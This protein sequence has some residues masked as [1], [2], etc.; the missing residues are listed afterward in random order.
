MYV[1]LLAIAFVAVYYGR[2][3]DKLVL[4]NEVADAS[5]MLF[6]FVAWMG[7]DVELEGG[8]EGNK[9]EEVEPA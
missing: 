1:Q 5:L 7:D 4:G 2:D 6:R 9:E 3:H 8:R